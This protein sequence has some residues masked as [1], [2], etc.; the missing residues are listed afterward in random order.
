MASGF[1]PQERVAESGGL[2]EVPR[3]VHALTGI[4][5]SLIDG[6]AAQHREAADQHDRERREAAEH[7]PGDDP[8][9]PKPAPRSTWR[10]LRPQ[11]NA[12]GG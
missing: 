10:L 3:G 1:A 8:G 2:H 6:D 11:A 4:A 12:T 9:R 5:A 7:K